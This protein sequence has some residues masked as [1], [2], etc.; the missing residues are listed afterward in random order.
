MLVVGP[1]FKTSSKFKDIL[2]KVSRKKMF[3]PPNEVFSEA[4]LR[5]LSWH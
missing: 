3:F 1:R 2:L 4:L 5:E